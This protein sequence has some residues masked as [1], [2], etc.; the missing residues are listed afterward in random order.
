MA[1]ETTYFD[2]GKVTITSARVIVPTQTYAMSGITSVKFVEK[3][4]QRLWP[5]GLLLAGFLLAKSIPGASIWHFVMLIAPGL[6]WLLIQRTMYSVQ[7]SSSS[8]ESK[9]LTS[10][11][12]D[13]VKN[14][15]K[16]INQAIVDRG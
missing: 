5:I 9:A 7:L 16:A 3:K 14:V 12:G 6:I 8:G 4:P 2:N 13:F 11:Y 1:V 10:K 15:V